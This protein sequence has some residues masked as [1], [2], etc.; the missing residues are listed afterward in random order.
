MRIFLQGVSS[1]GNVENRDMRFAPCRLG[2]SAAIRGFAAS[3]AITIT[4]ILGATRGYSQSAG[5]SAGVSASSRGN[6]ENGQQLYLKFGC[7]EC[8][9]LQGQGSMA[10]GPRIGPDPIPFSALVSYLRHPAGE[11]APYSNK[12]VSDQE[13]ADVYAFL[14]S[15]PTPPDTKTIPLL[16]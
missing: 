12:V 5:Q 2:N 15:L 8:H 14:E 6:A 9:S 13:L 16:H 3:V 7:Y 10:S 11:M 4:L 1:T